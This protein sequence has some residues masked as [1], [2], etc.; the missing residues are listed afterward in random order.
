MKKHNCDCEECREWREDHV[1]GIFEGTEDRRD[2]Y[3]AATE[4]QPSDL[5]VFER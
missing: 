1:Y 3:I 2:D 5:P 4:I